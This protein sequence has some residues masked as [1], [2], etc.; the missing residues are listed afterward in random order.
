MLYI[1][2]TSTDEISQFVYISELFVRRNLNY[3]FVC[4]FSYPAFT[5]IES[6]DEEGDFI[7]FDTAH[8]HMHVHVYLK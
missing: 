3:L 2:S 4:L 7:F 8:A 5:K 1:G 6:F